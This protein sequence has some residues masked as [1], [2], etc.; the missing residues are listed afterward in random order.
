MCV[1]KRD[2]TANLEGNDGSEENL[3]VAFEILQCTYTENG[4]VRN[5]GRIL[6]KSPF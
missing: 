6:C 4:A 2:I 3:R 1:C 5:V